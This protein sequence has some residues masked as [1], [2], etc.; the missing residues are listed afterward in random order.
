M[1]VCCAASIARLAKLAARKALLGRLS[2]AL[3]S[4]RDALSSEQDPIA[5]HEHTA[6]HRAR[7]ALFVKIG[8]QPL[9]TALHVNQALPRR[10][11]RG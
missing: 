4:G 6:I 10:G 8:W 9:E 5:L 1:R 7:L 2:Q 3:C 11:A